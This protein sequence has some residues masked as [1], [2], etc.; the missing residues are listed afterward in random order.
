M[1]KIMLSVL[2]ATVTMSATLEA[3][4]RNDHYV[5]NQRPLVAQKYTALPLGAIKPKGILLKNL[6]LQRDGLTGKL[7]SVY[8][9]V[10]GDNNG[11]LGG[12]GDGWERGPYWI[13]GLVPLAYILDDAELKA[14]AQKWIDWSIDNQMAN[15]YFGPRPLPKGYKKIKG[16]QQGQRDDW[17]PKMVMLKAIQQYYTATEDVRALD[18][19]TRYFQYMYE[20]LPN[21]PLNHVDF[22]YW[23]ERRGG[24]NLQVVY[25]LYNITGDKFLL[26]LGEMIQSQTYDWATTFTDNS[27]RQM[28]PLPRFHCV[29]VAQGVKAP[30]IYYQQ[31]GDEFYL[32][33]VKEGLEALKSTHGFVTGM[34]GG[35][36][37]L[38]GNNPTQGSELCTAT[39]LMF[40]LESVLPISGDIY[41]ADY[42]E[43][44]AYNVLPTQYT[45]DFMAKQYYQQTNQVLV[46]DHGRNFFHDLN[47][48]L[49]YGTTSGYPCCLTN[50]HQG[51]P[52]FVQNLWY[53]T[54]D[55]GLAA[56]VYGESVVTAKV[57]KGTEVSMEMTTKY[58]FD[59]T[60][61]VSY[62]TNEV[63]KFPLHLRIP[64][65]CMQP[66]M[67][68]NGEQ[69][70]VAAHNG[71]VVLDR[72][73]SKDDKV[74]LQFPMEVRLS[75]WFENSIGV[76]RGPLV[77]ALKVG[78]AWIET[79]RS[80]AYE[81]ADGAGYEDPFWEVH[82]TTPWN[83]ALK[84]EIKP[85]DFKF[86]ELKEVGD[87]PW[88]LIGAPVALKVKA[89]RI[90]EWTLESYSA[91]LMKIPSRPQRYPHA[92]ETEIT[93]IPYGCTTLRI[94]QFPAW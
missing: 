58:P 18:L 15:G 20:E 94:A 41:Y 66:K 27:F 82:S 56:L 42:L 72:I 76:E 62:L 26:K 11:W 1:K 34:Y 47:A 64:A 38:H 65:W 78:E 49:V 87:M 48:R 89:K 90:A 40:S 91:G 77:Y 2:L 12:T 74:T 28:N 4:G 35:D 46:T 13:D 31:S 8:S 6:E 67:T 29:N 75:N 24:D 53:A 23:A 59:E 36:E 25:W 86:V 10:C 51:W 30:A 3:K 32:N 54:P 7:D 21:R 14:K 37:L 44:V 71:I 68:V 83:Y 52:K 9:I 22:A 33:A 5:T 57:A 79:Q 43:K 70:E 16:T 17:W 55:N 45:D 61:E 63:V 73:W 81:R 50:M 80:R 19:M 85:A 84:K 69:V 60:I 88:N 92:P 39:E 93:L